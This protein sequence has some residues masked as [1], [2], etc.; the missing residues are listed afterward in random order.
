MYN[1]LLIQ[2]F[3]LFGFVC[4]FG[5]GWLVA[6]LLFFL[7]AGLKSSMNLRS[8]FSFLGISFKVQSNRNQSGKNYSKICNVRRKFAIT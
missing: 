7:L 2:D 5:F 3:I 8:L 1:M 4:L 6:L